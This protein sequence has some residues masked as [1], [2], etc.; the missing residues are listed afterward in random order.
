MISWFDLSFIVGTW[1]S[2]VAA[3][4]ASISAK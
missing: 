3:V 1:I 2:P 4:P